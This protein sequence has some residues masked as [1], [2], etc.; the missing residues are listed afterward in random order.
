MYFA[1]DVN[2]MVSIIIKKNMC[3]RLYDFYI[4]VLL[5]KYLIH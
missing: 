1:I 3:I 5:M 4:S 2:Q